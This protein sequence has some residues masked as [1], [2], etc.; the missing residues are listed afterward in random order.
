MQRIEFTSWQVVALTAVLL[1][2][3]AANIGMPYNIDAIALSFDITNTRAGLVA[4]L[5]MAAIAC[6]NLL[7]ARLAG[8][9]NP[10][11]VYFLG[12]SGIVAFNTL[13]L[14]TNN[15]T[16]LLLLRVPAGFALGAVAATIMA[17]AARSTK[18]EM[19][20]GII[21]SMV[22]VLGMALGFLMP[23]ALAMHL[24]ANEH[25]A[26]SW[27]HWNEMD[28]L[29]VVYIL[30]SLGALLFIRYT[31]VPAPAP[32]TAQDQADAKPIGIGWLALFGLGVIFHGHGN[33]GIFLVILGR[34][35]SLEVEVVGYVLMAG[36]GIGIGLP[37]LTGY[38]GSRIKPLAPMLVLIALMTLGALILANIDRSLAF[39]LAAPLFAVL[40]MAL[41]PIML[42]VL[43]RLDPSGALAGSHPAF[44]LVAGAAAPFVGGAISDASGGFAATGWFAAAC[45]W[46]GF[47]LCWPVLRQAQRPAASSSHQPQDAAPNTASA[48]P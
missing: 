39:I 23:R 4:S 38:I 48:S 13:S 33:L 46:L 29:F 11:R 2:A 1:L 24:F 40:P 20:F 45:F 5:E 3:F 14:F 28:G 16:E 21:N 6:G 41:M 26:L 37:L 15:V 35:A 17:T 30:F 22:G 47:S 8:K 9:L 18:P 36:A 27:T 42:G 31:P 12:A 25:P 34:E 10:H 7:L 32:P 43:A 19:T 44:V